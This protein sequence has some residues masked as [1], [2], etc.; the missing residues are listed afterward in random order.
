MGGADKTV[1]LWNVTDRSHPARLGR[2][3]TGPS[4]YV[5]SVAFSPG[6]QT[7]AAGATD[8]TVWLWHVSNPARPGLVA[9]LT[10]PAEQ[11]FSV[12]FSPG[13]STLAAGSADGTVRLW[14]TQARAAAT[15]VCAT[16]GQPLT[17]A[18]W[19]DYLPGRLYAPP[20]G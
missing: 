1:R 20:C 6:G 18:E 5:Y 11:V 9:A 15:E 10:G 2:P 16:A 17:R 8:H 7:L 4:G 14:D 3:L 19:A 13:G 12:A